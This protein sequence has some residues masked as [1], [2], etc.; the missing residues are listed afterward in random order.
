[1]V[2]DNYFKR[3]Q[4]ET[5]TQFFCDIASIESLERAVNWGAVGA[6]SNP[7]RVS[8]TVR[9]DPEHWQKEVKRILSHHPRL[10]DEESVD[11]LTRA[12][13]KRASEVLLPVYTSTKG[14]MGYLSMQ[15]SP[16]EYTDLDVLI[17]KAKQYAKIA[18]NIAVKIPIHGEGLQAIEELAAGGIN[19][20]ATT[21]YSVSQCMAAAEAHLR[22]L[23]RSGNSKPASRCLVVIVVGRLDAHFYNC[24]A[25]KNLTIPQEL[26]DQAGIAVAKKIYRLLKEH[27]L[28]SMLLSAGARRP[29]HFTDFVGGKMGVTIGPPIQKELIKL[30]VP[31]ISCIEDFPA[32]EVIGELRQKLPDYCRAYDED[33]LSAEQMRNF[34]PCLKLEQYFNDGFNDLMD[35]VHSFR[36]RN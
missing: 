21:G 8:R 12:V 16:R 2:D 6:T 3:V 22:G 34:G 36:E 29:E 9:S 1:M 17:S 31:V 24:I 32:S 19:I 30:N 27:S 28:P 18:P 20:T 5:P 25:E 35:F 4:K 10:P 15:G 14:Q 13:V 33:G 7:P 23:N 11:L 26:V